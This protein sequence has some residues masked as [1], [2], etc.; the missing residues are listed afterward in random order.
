MLFIIL[1]ISSF[2]SYFSNYNWENVFKNGNLELAE[3]YFLDAWND[4][5]KNNLWALYYKKWDFDKAKNIFESIKNTQK[6]NLNFLV[7]SSLW[8]TYYRIGEKHW[9]VQEKKQNWQKSIENY[10]TALEIK[11][12]EK[13]EKNKEFVEDK[14]KELEKQEE[15]KQD[16]TEQNNSSQNQENW[17]QNQQ[18]SNQSW[19]TEENS[20]QSQSWSTE[21]KDWQNSEENK[22]SQDWEK[23]GWKEVREEL[24]ASQKQELEKYEQELENTQKNFSNYFDKNYKESRDKFFSDFFNFSDWFDKDKKDW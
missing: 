6:N 23:K 10:K 3:K 7:N 4:F 16:K 11:K 21:E 19:T 1:N 12:D 15:Q 5:W 17:N 22:D 24:T 8:N 18:N 2:F 20:N 14:L 9:D 13:V